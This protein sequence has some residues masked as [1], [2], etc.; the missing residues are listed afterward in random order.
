[1]KQGIIK[2]STTSWSD[3]Y[4]RK[5]LLKYIKVIKIEPD[6]YMD[7]HIIR[8]ESAYFYKEVKEGG[9]LPEYIIKLATMKRRPIFGIERKDKIVLTSC[10][11]D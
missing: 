10:T 6:I 11:C 5:A 8:C 1:M 9:M 2:I 7:M 4:I 3:K